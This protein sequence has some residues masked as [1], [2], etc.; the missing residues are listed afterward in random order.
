MANG[1]RI[2]LKIWFEIPAT[3]TNHDMAVAKQLLRLEANLATKLEEL[4]YDDSVFVYNPLDYALEVHSNFIN[5]FA[6][7]SPKT[8]LFLGMN[9]GK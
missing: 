1:V 6:N 2:L 8:V 4:E 9:P 7:V 3:I 5:R